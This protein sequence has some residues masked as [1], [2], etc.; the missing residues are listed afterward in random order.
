MS[1]EKQQS[2]VISE[3]FVGL[4]I[5]SIGLNLS[6]SFLANLIEIA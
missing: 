1:C 3:F 6:P 5:M 4:Y 2:G